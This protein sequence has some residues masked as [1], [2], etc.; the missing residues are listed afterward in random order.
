M[1][2]PDSSATNSQPKWAAIVNDRLVPMPRRWLPAA[3]VLHQSGEQPE[4]TLVRDFNSPND[5]GFEPDAEIDLGEGNV[6]R[7]LAGCPRRREVRPDAPP[8]LAFVVDDR[9]EVTIQARQTGNTLRGLLNIPPEFVL[10]RDLETPNDQPVGDNER[11]TFD[12]GPVFISQRKGVVT[13]IVEGTPHEWPKP[14]ISYVEVATLFDPTYPQHPETYP[15]VTF[16]RGPASNPEGILSPGA[17]VNVKNGM[18][19]NVSPTGQS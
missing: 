3:V 12:E 18:V 16:E 9:Y 1:I 7:A 13:I 5:I 19:F 17:S 14:R 8:K 11:L 10:L 15:S 2:A 6:F 4:L